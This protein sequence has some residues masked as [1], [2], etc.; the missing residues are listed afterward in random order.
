LRKKV[1]L[2]RAITIFAVCSFLIYS[3]GCTSSVTIPTGVLTPTATAAPITGTTPIAASVPSALLDPAIN[4][5]SVF[6]GAST[7]QYWPLPVHNLGIAGQTTAQVLARFKTDVVGHGYVRVIIL[8]GANDVIQNLPNV[9]TEVATNLAAMGQIAT[10]AGI[11]VVLSEL[12]P[13]TSNGVDMNTIV[14]AVN[15]SIVQLAQQRGYQLVDYYT[16][17]YGHPEYFQTDGIHPTTAG[18]TVMESV[19]AAVLN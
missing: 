15:V 11:Q 13:E 2:Q 4:A 17:M 7:I 16:P 6:E 8:C 18:Y 1:F 3:G 10:A 9:T 14:S 5:T 12:P 19:L